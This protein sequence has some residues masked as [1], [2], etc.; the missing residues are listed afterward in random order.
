[1]L[2]GSHKFQGF[3]GSERRLESVIEELR[4]DGG[5]WA[6]VWYEPRQSYRLLANRPF[7]GTLLHS[8]SYCTAETILATIA[9]EPGCRISSGWRRHLQGE[10]AGPRGNNVAYGTPR[11][12]QGKPT[13]PETFE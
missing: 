2:G 12:G 5:D 9:R 8:I 13:M 4:I 11:P 1:M 6:A 10:A 3:V 7:P